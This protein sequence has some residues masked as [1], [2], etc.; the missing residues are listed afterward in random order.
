MISAVHGKDMG[1]YG[2]DHGSLWKWGFELL[3]IV[4][5]IPAILSARRPIFFQRTAYL[6]VKVFQNVSDRTKV[7]DKCPVFGTCPAACGSGCHIK[8]ASGQQNDSSETFKFLNEK[9]M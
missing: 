4:S 8:R 5:Q 3:K 9:R 2:D 7:V 6:E 1:L